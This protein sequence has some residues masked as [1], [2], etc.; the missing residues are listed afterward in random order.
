MKKTYISPAMDVTRV[1]A[2]QMIAASIANVG[3][4]SDIQLGDG[5]TPTTADA[6]VNPFGESI[7]D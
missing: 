2:E 3:G 1:I 7:F 6:P 4:N 5:E